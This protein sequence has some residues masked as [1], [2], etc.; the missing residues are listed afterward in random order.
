M[1]KIILT[2][3]LM[4][5]MMAQAQSL[6]L[7]KL[8]KNFGSTGQWQFGIDK[9]ATAGA[10]L[11]REVHD[12][13]WLAGPCRDVLILARNGAKAAHLGA[14]VMYNAD[15][16]NATYSL[17]AGVNVGSA[18]KAFLVELSQKAPL[19]ESI[20]D[21][22]APKWAAYLGSITT[23]DYAVGYRPKHNA[24]VKGNWTH[25]PM[26]KMDFPL[27]DLYALIKLGI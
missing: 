12:G 26:F 14:A 24:D 11:Q 22:K 25:G 18:S 23:L 3:A 19:L 7:Y 8:G 1:K 27:E 21:L 10:C 5:P 9:G 15:R 2:V 6:D 4:A 13:Q 17:R 16:G 20:G